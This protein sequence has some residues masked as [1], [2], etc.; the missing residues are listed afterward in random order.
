M[1]GI[2]LIALGL[3]ALDLTGIFNLESILAWTSDSKAPYK[4]ASKAPSVN[5]IGPARN[6]THDTKMAKTATQETAPR[7]AT[8]GAGTLP[9]ESPT[10][11]AQE[12]LEAPGRI[13][14][15]MY[16]CVNDHPKFK[17]SIERDLT[18]STRTFKQQLDLLDT[19][20]YHVVTLDDAYDAMIYGMQLPKKPVVLTFDDG[21]PDAY[22]CVFPTLRQRKMRAAFFVKAEEV[23]MSRGLDWAKV[24]EMSDAGMQI[25]SHT[26]NHCDLAIQ[27]ADVLVAQLMG[28]KELI[29][30]HTDKPVHFI[31]Y[32][33]GSYNRQVIDITQQSGYLGGLTTHPG[34]WRPG[35]NLFEL[36]RI[37]VS[38]GETLAQFSYQLSAGY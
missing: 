32:P 8:I 9:K 20:G 2:T 38:R 12:A 22:T 37:R 6:R 27:G 18:I 31:A 25:E 33:A 3:F 4:N 24:K 19:K 11:V 1:L 21:A 16:H 13:P 28:S 7:I 35:N 34:L 17:N 15:L 29:E 5:K 14:V 26:L 36:K 10:T 30:R 23:N